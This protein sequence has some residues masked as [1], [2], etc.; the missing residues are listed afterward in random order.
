MTETLR[1]C[2]G[3]LGNDS[4]VTMMACWALSRIYRSLKDMPRQEQEQLIL[5]SKYSQVIMIP[6][7][8]N[9]LHLQI[10][11]QKLKFILIVVVSHYLKEVIEIKFI[12]QH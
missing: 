10:Q 1:N 3:Q 8:R 9:I 11:E 2:S 4:P 6:F 7:L 12:R 5:V